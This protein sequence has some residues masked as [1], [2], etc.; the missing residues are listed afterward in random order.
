MSSK[1]MPVRLVTTGRAK[2]MNI[3]E[4]EDAIVIEHG[5]CDDRSVAIICVSDGH[6]MG[7]GQYWEYERNNSAFYLPID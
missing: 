2:R 1:L 7:P 6:Y 5:N 4:W 3:S